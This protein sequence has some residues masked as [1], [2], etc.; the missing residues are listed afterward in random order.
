MGLKERQEMNLNFCVKFEDLKC[1]NKD[2]NVC[3]KIIIP[4]I[5]FQLAKAYIQTREKLISRKSFNRDNGI[6]IYLKGRCERC[7]TEYKI[8]FI[9]HEIFERISVVP[10]KITKIQT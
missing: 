1:I 3:G 10:E 4:N 9:C 6:R 5:Y 8:Q 7:N 2:N